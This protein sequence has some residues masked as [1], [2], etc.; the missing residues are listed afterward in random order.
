MAV[1]IA[2]Y[3]LNSPGQD[4]SSLIGRIQQYTHCKAL[5]SAFF[6]DSSS[7]ASAIRDDLMRY[8]DK[9]DTLFVMELQKHWACNRSTTATVWLKDEARTWA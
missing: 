6:I 2:T 8:I 4:Y 3:D 1:Y 5:K 7:S 9:N